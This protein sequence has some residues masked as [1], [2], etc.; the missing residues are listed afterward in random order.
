MSLLFLVGKNSGLNKSAKK[1]I[2]R[3]LVSGNGRKEMMSV[4]WKRKCGVLQLKFILLIA[5]TL[6]IEFVTK[7]DCL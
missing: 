2:Y 7:I 5:K 3:L 1:F 6:P 4:Q